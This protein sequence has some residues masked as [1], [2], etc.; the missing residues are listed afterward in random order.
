MNKIAESELVGAAAARGVLDGSTPGGPRRIQA[1]RL[2]RCC[3]KLGGRV[4]P[5]GIRLRNVLVEGQLNLAGMAVPFPLLFDS[6]EF[7][8]AP[9]I[10]GAELHELALRDCG[11]CP[12]CSRTVCGSGGILTCL[13]PA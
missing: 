11:N 3:G 1:G 13:T 6:C 9:V 12:G 8:E 2:R 10:E 7:D 4:D 5:Y